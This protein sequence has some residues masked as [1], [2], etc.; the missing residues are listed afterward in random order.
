MI[1]VTRRD[2]LKGSAAIG[3]AGAL[4]GTVLNT[5][6]PSKAHATE[7]GI[8]WIPTTCVGCTTWCS[9]DVKT[10]TE[11]GV[12]RA[13]DVRGNKYSKRGDAATGDASNA[14]PRARL[15]LQ[16]AYDADRVKVPMRRTN[17]LKGRGVDPGFIPV[18]WDSAMD[19]MAD[20]MLQMRAAG[21]S[22]KYVYFRGRYTYGRDTLYTGIPKIYGSPNGISHSSICAEAENI[23]R[24]GVVGKY[25]YDDYDIDNCRCLLLWGV[26]PTASNRLVSGTIHKLGA[27]INAGMKVIA[28]DPRLNT[29]A[30]KAHYW[31]P[32]KP[33][34]DGALALAMAHHIL[35][36]GLW[37]KSFVGLDDTVF[38]ANNNAVVGTVAESGT[39]GLV[40]WWDMVLKDKTPAWAAGVTGISPLTIIKVAEEFAGVGEADDDKAR[41]ISWL[42]PGVA[43]QPNGYY[44]GKACIALNGLMGSFDHIGGEIQAEPSASVYSSDIPAYATYQDATATTGAG[45]QKITKYVASGLEAGMPTVEGN[46]PGKLTPTNRAGDAIKDESPYET[47]FI[48]GA[49]NNFVFS[50]T[51]TKRWEDGLSGDMSSWSAE[52]TT[53]DGAPPFV[54]H[55]TTHASEFSMFADIVLPGKHTGLEVKSS[56]HQR[57]G[58]YKNHNLYNAVISPVWPDAK[59]PESELPWKLAQ[60]LN[61]WGF[62]NLLNFLRTEYPAAVGASTLGVWADSSAFEDIHHKYHATKG[63]A[64]ARDT[65]WTQING[66]TMTT[67]SAYQEAGNGIYQ[68]T[69][70]STYF[71]SNG[72]GAAWNGL[73]FGTASGK[74]EFYNSGAKHLTALTSYKTKVT[75]NYS[76]FY[77]ILND[78]NYNDVA[79]QV[80]SGDANPEYV[81]LPNY[82]SPFY[83]KGGVNPAEYPYAYIDHKSR[84]NREGRSQNCGWYYEFKSNDPG[85]EKW[86]DV[87][88]IH[89]ADAY[90]IGVVDGDTVKITSPSNPTTGITCKVKVWNGVRA[91][92]VAKAYGQGHWAYGR[93][94][95]NSG[96]GNNNEILP[97]EWERINGGTARNGVTRVKI[98]KI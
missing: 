97:A 61:T 22:H 19:E 73:T 98:V 66:A 9:V 25:G 74:V 6:T 46:A 67:I 56:T 62:S 72:R 32:V 84:L 96:G 8:G 11:G 48:L 93:N 3:V 27:R 7:D 21:N 88:K 10:Q 29:A 33:G 82:E 87:I 52:G 18:D 23:C 60:A 70:A 64:G 55:A 57:S 38:T 65:L 91:G 77:D 54:V 24:E 26:D 95:S 28:V 14:C 4:S 34:T 13:I 1:K 20:K 30:A 80:G 68:A 58:M 45:K 35:V 83:N 76:T 86:K 44:N 75:P 50:C 53:S 89:P 31:L 92:T 39:M 71:D 90:V 2:F 42:G 43:M 85:D 78:C 49:M 94:A 40:T 59:N 51:G 69:Y 17:P 47:K 81:F 15:A 36:N 37:N 79:T 5:L 12:T 16:E 63:T 41:A